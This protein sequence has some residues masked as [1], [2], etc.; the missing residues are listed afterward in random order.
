MAKVK[1]ISVGY[2][3]HRRVKIGETISMKG[4]DEN[5]YYVDSSGKKKSFVKLDKNGKEVGKEERRCKWVDNIDTD[6]DK[7]VDPKEVAAVL[8]GKTPGTSKFS[9]EESEEFQPKGKA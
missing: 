6:L 1:A 3:N 2:Y 7:P 8:S 5:G 4:V 9:Q